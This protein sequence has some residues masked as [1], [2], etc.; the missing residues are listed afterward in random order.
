MDGPI[1]WGQV[2]LPISFFRYKLSH[3][4]Q[5]MQLHRTWEALNVGLTNKDAKDP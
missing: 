3:V 2:H 4:L 1:I 5:Y